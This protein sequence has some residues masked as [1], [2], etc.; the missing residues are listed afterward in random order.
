MKAPPEKGG[1]PHF[2]VKNQ[3]ENAKQQQK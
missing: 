3:P 1:K 2:L